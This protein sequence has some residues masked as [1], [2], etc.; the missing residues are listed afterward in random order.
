[1]AAEPVRSRNYLD[2]ADTRSTLDALRALGA[3]V[4]R[5]APTSVRDPRRAACATP[6]PPDGRD[7]RRQRRHADAAAARVAR[8]PAGRSVRRSTATSRSAAGRSTGSPSRCEL[9]GARIEARDGR[10]PPFT[11][12]GAPLTG[13][14]YELPVASAQVKSCV[15]LA[16]LVTDGA[17]RCRARADAR[18]HRAHAAARRACRSSAT[19]DG[20][21]RTTVGNVDELELDEIDVPGDP[22]SAAFLVAA[23]V[24][25]PGSRLRARG[26]RRQLDAHRASCGSLER[27]G[28]DRAR[29]P[30]AEP[31]ASTPIEPVGDL[32]V[33]RR[34]RSRARRSS[35]R[36]CRWRS[37]SCRSWRCWAASPRARRWCAAPA[38][39]A[40]R[41]PTGSP[42]W[43]RGCAALGADIEATADGF[44][45][46]GAG[47]LRGGTL[48]AHGD[49]R[50]A[51]L[52]AVAG[53]ASRGGRGGGG[54]GG[55]GGLLPGLR[56]RTWR[57][58]LR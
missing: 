56:A 24:L 27:M 51:M 15:L 28:R 30:R 7:R 3:I 46:R 36:R 43:S 20:G 2:A 5:A 11:V 21:V 1:M 17:R 12:H 52:G 33:A 29:R 18:P 53:L 49:H 39:C 45:V 41:S 37:T 40:S 16:G 26:R 13:I 38:S 32:D 48:D 47:G 31:G 22:S 25:V 23:G 54:D 19:A 6:R 58:L 10:F 4:E 55:R 35:P 34:R 44:V 8:G 42:P 57:G 50:L 14:E 9:M